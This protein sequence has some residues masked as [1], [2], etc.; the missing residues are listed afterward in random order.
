MYSKTSSCT[1]GRQGTRPDPEQFSQTIQWFL[2]ANPD[3]SCPAAG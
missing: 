1:I 2:K 3:D